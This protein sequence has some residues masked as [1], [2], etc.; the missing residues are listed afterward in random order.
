[1][2]RKRKNRLEVNFLDVLSLVTL[3][4]EEEEKMIGWAVFFLLLALVAAFF[5]FGGVAAISVDIA[6]ILFVVFIVLFLISAVAAAL[7]G[8]R[9]P[10]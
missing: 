5:G 2:G 10:V 6:Q 7:R 8:K 1:L 3:K 9:P 4:Y